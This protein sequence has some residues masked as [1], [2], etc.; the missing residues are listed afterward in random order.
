MA[1]LRELLA[2]DLTGLVQGTR[3]RKKPEAFCSAEPAAA[4]AP[5]PPAVAATKRKAPAAG[6]KAR[7]EY[8][9]GSS[10]GS[11]SPAG[12]A[13]DVADESGSRAAA[14]G[15]KAK[16][17]DAAHSASLG[18]VEEEKVDRRAKQQR[19]ETEGQRIQVMQGVEPVQQLLM[20]GCVPAEADQQLWSNLA[21]LTNKK[22]EA[23]AS[24]VKR[25]QGDYMV[26]RGLFACVD[27]QQN[28]LICV[29]GGELITTEEARIR[30]DIRDSQS[31]RYL[32][33]ISD[34]DFLVDGWHFALGIQEQALPGSGDLCWPW[35]AHATQWSQGPGPMANH[36]TGNDANATLCFVPL[37]KT[38]AVRLLPRIPTLR[39]HRLIRAGEEILFNY[40]TSL[41]FVAH[42]ERVEEEEEVRPARGQCTPHSSSAHPPP[43]PTSPLLPTHPSSAHLPPPLATRR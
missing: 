16:S 33:R 3:E 5:A 41:P 9:T 32:M 38:E 36:E 24:R 30:K 19:R 1:A 12:S 11:N 22:V 7:Q 34:S 20:L 29:Y 40:G 27:F 42:N 14:G 6:S 10:C 4:A 21:T 15:S 35:D 2:L 26:G 28:E 25:L 23:R 13:D 43:P 37:A 18:S 8:E 31:R 39:A 17:K